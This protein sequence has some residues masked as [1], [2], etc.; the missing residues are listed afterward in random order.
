VLS[1]AVSWVRSGAGR[2][3]LSQR[4]S[5]RKCWYKRRGWSCLLYAGALAKLLHFSVLCVQDLWEGAGVG[6]LVHTCQRTLGYVGIH[7]SGCLQCVHT[8]PM[9]SST[10]QQGYV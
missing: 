6:L 10:G 2:A 9:I 5:M 8:V 4:R 1:F 3:V 7:D